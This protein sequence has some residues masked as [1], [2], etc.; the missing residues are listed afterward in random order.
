MGEQPGARGKTHRLHPA[1]DGPKK[2][3]CSERRAEAEKEVHQR[4]QGQSDRHEPTRIGVI[5]EHSIDE[6]TDAVS[7]IQDGAQDAELRI[8]VAQVFAE[9][10]QSNGEIFAAKVKE[11][12]SDERP[13]HDANAPMTV[14][15][16]NGGGIG[17]AWS[18][19]AGLKNR[20]YA[21]PK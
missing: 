12:I 16:I 21:L 15:R 19:R 14:R 4:R 7:D 1:V 9:R 13:D 20:G 18:V 5:P 11:G 2:Q 6:F 8:G 17:E 10:G 3:E